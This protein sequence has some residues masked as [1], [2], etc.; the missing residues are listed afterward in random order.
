MVSKDI[1]QQI[2]DFEFG[3]V[4]SLENLSLS[5]GE[6]KAAV[7]SLGRLV[8]QGVIERLSPGNYYKPK[9]TAFGKVGPTIEDRFRD[10]LY[11]K[12]DPIDYL[13]GLYAINLL[14]LTTQ[15]PTVLEVG[16]NFPKR[17]VKRGIYSIRF[18][19]Q[20][21]LITEKNIEF[22]RILDSLKWIKKIPD[23]SVAR[24]YELLRAIVQGYCVEEQEQLVK[25]ALNY[26]PVTRALLGSMIGDKALSELLLETLSPLTRFKIGLSSTLISPQ[27]NIE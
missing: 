1:Q 8:Q 6:Q 20:R 7:M 19:L 9:E 13:T 21:N 18:V 26:S 23:T 10:L 3:K 22:L 27:W 15:Q 11:D 17:S 24:S 12:N 2:A 14:G 5:K 4:F 16:V 25:L